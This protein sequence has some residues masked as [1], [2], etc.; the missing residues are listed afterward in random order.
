MNSTNFALNNCLV[1]NFSR[2]FF[3][4]FECYEYH[5]CQSVISSVLSILLIVGTIISNSLV[6]MLIKR[7]SLKLTIF[8]KI[9]IGHSIVDGLTGL[10]AMP[11]YHIYFVFGYWPLGTIIGKLWSSFDN[12]INTITNV[13]MLYLSWSRL[14]SIQYPTSYNAEFLLKRPNLLMVTIWFLS[15]IM[16]VPIVV[17]FDLEYSSLN[18][19]YKNPVIGVAFV[20]LFWF[21]PL[22]LIFIIST[23]ICY[24]LYLKKSQ[25]S[26][27]HRRT[28]NTQNKSIFERLFNYKLESQTMLTI[29]MSI[30]WIQWIVP[31]LIILSKLVF[32]INEDFL[33]VTYWLTYSV[34]LTD[35]IILIIFNPNVSFLK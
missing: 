7:N 5:F 9:L 11:F 27:N 31:C 15:F 24:H 14:R 21:L 8:D 22:L 23:V 32:V 29:I 28:L 3:E 13:H 19:D 4:L 26:M 1:K 17:I 35:P 30:Y 25:F 16:W 34:C 2:N 10:I 20:F 12:S 18:L 6:I 33:S